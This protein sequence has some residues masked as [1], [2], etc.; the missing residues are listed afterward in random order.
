M[1]L[2]RKALWLMIII[3]AASAAIFAPFAASNYL[4]RVINMTMIT[5]ICVV[6]LFVIFGMAGQISFAQAGFWGVGAY[7][8][9]ILTVDLHVS[10]LLAFFASA[11]GTALLPAIL[12]IALFRLHGHYF[13]FSTIGV[14]MILNG[15]FQ[16]WKPVTG[17]ADGIANIPPFG[18]ASLT[19]N[20]E[21]S[22]FYLILFMVIAISVVTYLIHQ[23]SLGRAFMAIRDNEIAAKCMGVNSYLTKI[24]AFTISGFYCGIAGSLYAFMSS[25]VSA[26]SFTFPQ[27][28]LYLVML[29]LGGYQTLPGPIIGTALL[30]LLPEW[31]RFL[32]EYI[33]LI[34]GLGVMV[35]MVVM[36]DGLIGGGKKAYEFIRNKRGW[37]DAIPKQPGNDAG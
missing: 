8:S 29:M 5:Y 4:L 35:L 33:L 27:S 14:V 36:P 16:N 9:A 1:I 2:H 24:I 34:Y 26:S 31:F 11:F 22:L 17:G 20:T 13:G 12:G 6:S 3:I 37:T 10:P 19:F 21:M 7:I 18:I 23:S 30:M 15:L 25:Y 28:A 32:Q